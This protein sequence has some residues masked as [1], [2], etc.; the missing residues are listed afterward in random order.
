[1]DISRAVHINSATGTIYKYV[2][3]IEKN[4]II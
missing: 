3:K 4:I 1:M 2:K